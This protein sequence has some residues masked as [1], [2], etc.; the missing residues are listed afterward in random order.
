[1]QSKNKVKAQ[2]FKKIKRK[3][4]YGQCKQEERKKYNIKEN[5]RNLEKDRKKEQKIKR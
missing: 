3:Q 5:N 1:L 2:A 4:K